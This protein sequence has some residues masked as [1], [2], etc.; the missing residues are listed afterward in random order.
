MIKGSLTLETRE[1]PFDCAPLGVKGFPSWGLLNES[2]SCHEPLMRFVHLDNRIRTKLSPNQTEQWPT[3]VSLVCHN[4]SGRERRWE[5]NM[6]EPSFGQKIRGPLGI[7]YISW[8]NIGCNGKFIFCVNHKMQLP[9][10]H[11]LRPPMGV[12]FHRPA[13]FGVRRLRL[14]TIH[15]SLQSG[16]VYRHSFSKSRQLR[17]VFAYQS[18]GDIHHFSG[19]VVAREPEQ[20]TGERGLMGDIVGRRD[21]T[22]LSNKRIVFK[23]SDKCRR[24]RKAKNILGYEAV[25]KGSHRMSL[26]A[27]ANRAYQSSNA[28]VIVERVKDSPQLLDNRWGLP[29]LGGYGS[30]EVGHWGACPSL[31][32]LEGTGSSNACVSVFVET[33]VLRYSSKVNC[34]ER[35]IAA[36]PLRILNRSRHYC[37]D[38]VCSCPPTRRWL[39]IPH[40]TAGSSHPD[41]IK[42]PRITSLCCGAARDCFR[43]WIPGGSLLKHKNRLLSRSSLFLIRFSYLE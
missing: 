12:L 26:W 40:L 11:K 27:S 32:G 35:I 38:S 36:N 18:T 5:A 15:P 17:V 3:R 19:H 10:Q 41:N 37:F 30:L 42:S 16:A 28:R 2:L 8:G 13:S 39:R 31:A 6:G 22:Y 23:S 34:L 7:V 33:S 29:N 21:T 25:L 9:S 4:P 1:S 20:E 24:G 43:R 14:P